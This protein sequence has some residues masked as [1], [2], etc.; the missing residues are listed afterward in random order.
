VDGRAPML[1]QGRLSFALAST[2]GR[3]DYVDH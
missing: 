1:A 3:T 2:F